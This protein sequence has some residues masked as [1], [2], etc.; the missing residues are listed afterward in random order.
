MT[1]SSRGRHSP[2]LWA[3]PPSSTTRSSPWSGSGAMLRRA[4][5]VFFAMTSANTNDALQ[6]IE[7]A[8]ARPLAR[9]S[10]A[11]RSCWP[12]SSRRRPSRRGGA[13]RRSAPWRRSCRR[14]S[15]G[16]PG[17]RSPQSRRG[18]GA[19]LRRW[20]ARS[21]RRGCGR[22]GGPRRAAGWARRRD[23]LRARLAPVTARRSGTCVPSDSLRPR[24]GACA[25]RRSGTCVPSGFTRPPG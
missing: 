1:Q 4:V 2:R 15:A 3:N 7:Q 11:R 8:W 13:S 24:A 23:S 25:A 19:C 10:G 18:A 20:R 14:R 22:T 5:K 9:S 17:R 21:R 16:S 12:T 6:K